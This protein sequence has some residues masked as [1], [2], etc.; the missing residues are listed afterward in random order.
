[1]SL[2]ATSLH[3]KTTIASITP[4][5]IQA[6][7]TASVIVTGRNLKAVA[8][9]TVQP[10][11]TV[12]PPSASTVY[13]GCKA[14]SNKTGDQL[15][16]VI[17]GS[18]IPKA[19]DYLVM[20]TKDAIKDSPSSGYKT[21]DQT[22]LLAFRSIQ[23]ID[24][25]SKANTDNNSGKT[26]TNADATSP[27]TDCLSDQNVN[28]TVSNVSIPS[29]SVLCGS[30]IVPDSEVS[31]EF[32]YHVSKLYT[33][34]QVRVSNKN[35]QYDFLLRDIVLTLPDGRIVSSRIRRFAQ[36]VAV[37]GKTHD[38]RSIAFNSLTAVGGVYGALASFG[39]AGYTTAGNVLQ[40]AFMG[41][42]NQIFPDYT[43]DNVNR[44]NNAVFDD[45]NPSIVPKD[46]IGQPPLYVMA[47][48]PKEPG[49]DRESAYQNAKDILVSIEG[50]FIKQ[51]TLLSLSTTSIAFKPQ[52][53]SPD[54]I[55]KPTTFDFTELRK[56]S[57]EQSFTISDTGSTPINIH[58][59]KI[60]PS[61]KTSTGSSPD[62]DVVTAHSNCGVSGANTSASDG[63]TPF[64]IAPNASC[65]ITV[66]FH[67]T[68]AGQISATVTF[69]GDNLE[70]STAIA[71]SGTGVG[72]IFQSTDTSASP[73]ASHTLACSYS[74]ASSCTF[75]IGSQKP[76]ETAPIN[77]YYF[78]DSTTDKITMSTTV[79]P[80]PA[81]TATLTSSGPL[82]AAGASLPNPT[83]IKINVP[84]S[85]SSPTSIS[86]TDT[87]LFKT[88]FTVNVTYETIPT[89]IDS[90]AFKAA[91]DADNRLAISSSPSVTIS[92]V[93]VAAGIPTGNVIF[94]FTNTTG[95]GAPVTVSATLDANGKAVPNLGTLVAGKYTMMASY[96]GDGKQFQAV[97]LSAP[98]TVVVPAVATI[99]IGSKPVGAALNTQV[100]IPVTISGTT[101]TC[102]GTITSTVT[103][104]STGAV[105]PSTP[106]ALTNGT[107]NVTFTPTTA[108]N[109]EIEVTYA[110]DAASPCGPGSHKT[111][112]TLP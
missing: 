44:F 33:V 1:M 35:A 97:Q 87:A 75:D 20:L 9:C 22:T 90:A 91:L 78:S 52:F 8:G 96:P 12:G 7:Q 31:D 86:F 6:N 41:S 66:R 10:V 81:I 69:D 11:S 101:S 2:S 27:Y 32:G 49:L 82:P 65:K 72:V 25:T 17:S 109:Y 51:V 112:V 37:K 42:F 29:T 34:I 13:E 48:V 56:L 73:T 57:E 67:P 45:Q 14:R 84:A 40:G 107:G 21:F 19:G 59:F 89:M 3:G 61:G 80:G 60:I 58:S 16:L 88:P 28:G 95:V 92:A 102:T 108:G 5:R 4:H 79:A 47:L 62:F 99:S 106:S 54:T 53:I 77:V 104:V 46:S 50:T 98:L 83:P 105:V 111:P 36:G 76:N 39:S 94:T 38:R 15:I 70:G 24:A 23:V 85:G 30:S 100:P 74:S 26:T 18:L 63:S 55:F 93:P 71:L 43:A 110:P 103:L 64:S 68:T